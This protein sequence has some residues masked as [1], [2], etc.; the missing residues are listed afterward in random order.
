MKYNSYTLKKAENLLEEAAYVLRYEKGSFNAGFCV[1]EE[2]KVVVVNKYFDTA[3]KVSTLLE[4]ILKLKIEKEILSEKTRAFY[5]EV[6]QLK[7][8]E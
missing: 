8:I 2:K 1:L 7:L 5:H 4:I 6:M 3:A